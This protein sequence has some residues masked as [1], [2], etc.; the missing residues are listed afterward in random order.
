MSTPDVKP[1]VHCN[2]DAGGWDIM[3]LKIT[4]NSWLDDVMESD[5]GHLSP[6]YFTPVYLYV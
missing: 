6:L 5:G 3:N 4:E 1:N 2:I